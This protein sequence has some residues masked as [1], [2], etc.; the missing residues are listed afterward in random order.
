MIDVDNWT[1]LDKCFPNLPLMKLSA[2]HKAQGDEVEWYDNTKEYDI[3][4]LSKVFSFT[5]DYLEDIHTDKIIKGGTGYAIHLEGKTE[6]FD[7]S[8]HQNLPYEIEHIFPDYALYNIQN[9]AY[10]F[11]SRGCPRGCLFCHVRK[12]R[13]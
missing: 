13:R 10:G 1:K 9:T 3:C 2:W 8:M 12:K 11:M 7:D 6:I 5:S 4:Y